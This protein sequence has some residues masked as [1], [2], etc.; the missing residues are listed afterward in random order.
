MMG[1]YFVTVLLVVLPLSTKPCL[2]QKD[3]GP[4]TVVRLKQPLIG[5][6]GFG[7]CAP[8]PVRTISHTVLNINLY[9][10]KSRELFLKK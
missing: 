8:G 10:L 5:R 9:P 1:H 3:G 2:A 6:G 4:E 7:S